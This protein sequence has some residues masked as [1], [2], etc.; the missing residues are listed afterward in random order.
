MNMWITFQ[1]MNLCSWNF[2]S[3]H[4]YSSDVLSD[5]I[6]LACKLSLDA[7]MPKPALERFLRRLLPCLLDTT[8]VATSDDTTSNATFATITT[9]HTTSTFLP[10][11]AL[12]RLVTSLSL[13]ADGE[14]KIQDALLECIPNEQVSRKIGLWWMRSAGSS[15]GFHKD[16]PADDVHILCSIEESTKWAAEVSECFDVPWSVWVIQCKV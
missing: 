13:F 9:P 4:S 1:S 14:P 16:G 6:S 5:V 12:A 2:F 15:G 10:S 7:S 11:A 3:L 8:Q